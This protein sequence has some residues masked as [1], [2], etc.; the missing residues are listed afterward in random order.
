MY[1][2][3]RSG[4]KRIGPLGSNQYEPV[5]DYYT[6]SNTEQIN[7][8]FSIG[9]CEH[10]VFV[11]YHTDTLQAISI[12]YRRDM[13]SLAKVMRTYTFDGVDTWIKDSSTIRSLQKLQKEKS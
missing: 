6:I 4:Y 11:L 9:K 10:N 1:L 3:Y 2:K 13:K 12:G 5:Y 7:D 8:Q